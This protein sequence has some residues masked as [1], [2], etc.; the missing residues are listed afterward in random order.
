MGAACAELRTSFCLVKSKSSQVKSSQVKSGKLIGKHF[1]VSLFG[2]VQEQVEYIWMFACS[3]F[4][5]YIK[6]DFLS[7]EHKAAPATS[8]QKSHDGN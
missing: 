2:F 4:I 7:L 3:T 8:T 5:G 1:A 6:L